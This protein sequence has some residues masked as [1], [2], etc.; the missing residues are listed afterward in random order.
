MT[1]SVKFLAKTA[2]TAALYVILTIVFAPISFGP[3]QVRIAAALYQF[4]A[5]DKRYYL[6]MVLGVA[7]A[8]L[9][10]PF[11][12]VDVLAGLVIA[13]GGLAAA[14]WLNQYTKSQNK[15][16]LITGICTTVTMFSV[17]L[18]LKFIGNVPLPFPLLYLYLMIGQAISQVIGFI[19][20]SFLR[21]KPSVY[22]KIFMEEKNEN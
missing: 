9:Y 11:G 19:F 7:L 1:L 13:G 16:A 22:T 15:R 3:V 18:V 8:N 6:G 10:S 21:T 17:A 14:I 20:I 2:I 5:V 4:V 12:L